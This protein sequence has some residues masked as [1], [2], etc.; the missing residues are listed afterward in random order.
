[1]DETENEIRSNEWPT[2]SL[3]HLLKQLL[4]LQTR[5]QQLI[6]IKRT[7]MAHS[8]QPGIDTINA[9]IKEKT[10]GTSLL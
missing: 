8:V 5:Q 6:D 7:D 4:I 9:I 3:D 1:M 2:M 10:K